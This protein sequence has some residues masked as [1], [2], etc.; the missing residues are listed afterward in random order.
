MAERKFERKTILDPAVADLLTG[1][2]QRQAEAA[3]P[4]KERERISRE[5][6]KIQ[7]RRD[8]RATYDLPP[9]LR[10]MVRDLAEDLRLPA[11][12]LVTLALVRFL[13][14]YANGLIDLG[15]YKQPSRSPRY[16]WN[17]VFPEALFPK[18]KKG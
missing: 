12:Q 10:E 15:K 5:R 2:E 13:S 17:L 4:R 18:R 6:A 7:S 1:M 14:D 16:D 9:S 8:Q 3:L 11:S